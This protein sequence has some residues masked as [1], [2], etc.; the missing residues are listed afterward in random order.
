MLTVLNS[1]HPSP[2]SSIQ[3]A[4]STF[5]H[6]RREAKLPAEGKKEKI[7]LQV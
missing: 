1:P 2:S 3:D 4:L 5:L 7:V 6:F